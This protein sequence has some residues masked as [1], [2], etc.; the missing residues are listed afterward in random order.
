MR[1]LA[2][3]AIAEIAVPF[4]LIALGE[5]HVSSLAAIVV[6]AT[7]LFGALLALRFDASERAGGLRLA[8]LVLGLAGVVALVGIDVAAFLLTPAVALDAPTE[9]PSAGAI[10]A[11]ATLGLLCT[12]VGFVLYGVLIVEAGAGRALVITYVNPVVAV[13]LGVTLLGERP[14]LG[15]AADSWLST[16]GRLPLAARAL[17]SGR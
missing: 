2:A 1:W 8:G 10:V 6:A 13:A 16:D 11:L 17:A 3:F 5:Q 12:A 4:P 7:P 9:V 14:G 15:A